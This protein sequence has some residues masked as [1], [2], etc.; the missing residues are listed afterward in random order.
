MPIKNYSL[1]AMESE[2]M[3]DADDVDVDGGED[4]VEIPLSVMDSRTHLT[5]ETK[6]VVVAALYF[7]SYVLLGG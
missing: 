3:V 7:K 1:M 2:H 5:P 4:G 6:I